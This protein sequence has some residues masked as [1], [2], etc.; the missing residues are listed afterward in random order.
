MSVCVSVC[1]S[2][3]KL[4]RREWGNSWFIKVMLLANY[5]AKGDDV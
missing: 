4:L 3:M 2:W 1:V 5:A